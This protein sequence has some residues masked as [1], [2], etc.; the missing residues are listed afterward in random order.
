MS[1]VVAKGSES[2]ANDRH[3][4]VEPDF[5]TSPFAPFASALP[6]G[7]LY[8]QAIDYWV[9]A[10][11]RSAIFLDVLKQR[12]N[13]HLIHEQETAPTVL[14]FDFEL[15]LDGRNF[16]H[17]VNYQLLR[18]LPPKGVIMDPR[19][20][21][22]IVFD[23]RAG[24]GPGIGG[25]KQD[26][27]IGNAMRAGHPCYFVSFLPKPIPG[28]TVGQVCDAEAYF[29]ARVIENHPEA[30]KPCLIGNCQA[31]WQIAL[32]G[33]IFPELVGVLILA[34]A[35]LSY[36]AGVHG[37][38]PMRYTGGMTG[39]AWTTVLSGDLGKGLF[40]GAVLVENFEKL[41][42]A[43][44]HWKKA[45]NLYSKVDVEASRF[46]EFERWWGSPIMLGADEMQF[47]VDHLFIGNRLG[48]T[49]IKSME[50]LTVDLRN[51]KSPIVVFCSQADD[52][53]PPPQAL[54]WVLD[55]YRTDNEIVAAGQ[56][57]I[58]CLHQSIGHL[59]IFV[60]SSVATK[61]HDKFVQNIDLIEMLPPGLYEA[62]FIEKSTNT[63][64]AD[65]ASGNHVLRFETRKLEDIR[66]LGCNSPEDDRCFA[67]VKRVSDTLK[68][69][70]GNFVSPWVRAFST[71]E[72]AEL[73]RQM[74]PIRIRYKMFSDQN[75]LLSATAPLAALARENRKPVPTDNVFWQLQEM[76]ST[77]IISTL[78]M[79]RD[80]RDTLTEQLFF[81]IY[82]SPLLQAAVGLRSSRDH[83]G[84]AGRDLD[85]E[86]SSQQSVHGLMKM[87]TSGG[88]PEAM[89]R[90]VLYIVRGGGFD[91]REFNV[92]RKLCDM[93]PSLAMTQSA[94][95]ALVRQQ[96]AM[97]MV[98]EKGTMEAIAKLLDSTTTEAE[99]EALADINMV[100]R[101][102]GDLT[103]EEERRLKQLEQ[104]FV[105]S[106]TSLYRR[107][108]DIQVFVDGD[109][110]HRR[111]SDSSPLRRVNDFPVLGGTTP[112]N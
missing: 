32:T 94:F 7:F 62:V 66:R 67:T 85:R 108:N 34:G 97:L 83:F 51:I 12:S 73:M 86:R 13:A 31:G 9:D 75:L 109:N 101:S 30:D 39:G 40:D 50:G 35:P 26:S 96:S 24:H 95:K 104:Y 65:L 82:G 90:A 71:E 76:I 64:R 49:R 25:M 57:I 80:I 91:E 22:F 70:Y 69:L 99:K 4:T 46:L 81:A 100:F 74:H 103:L 56:T 17:P 68:G 45:Y 19:K 6:C 77:Q 112:P 84:Q 98:D 28:Q 63:T 36:W 2:A 78:D 16:V 42:P 27:E 1:S 37:K 48:K 47:I 54:D 11:Q 55:L 44:T 20:R 107:V 29:I 43:N 110:P 3:G 38:S 102:C 23:P 87:A 5:S 21:P 41:N 88:L 105:S 79:Y 52:I 93:S 72:S 53:T 111:A 92:L 59:G 18:I 14:H 58:Y 61:E 33:A 89:V 15:V 10:W 60:S 106:H 8:Q